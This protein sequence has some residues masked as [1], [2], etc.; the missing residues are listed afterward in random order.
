VRLHPDCRRNTFVAI[1]QRAL[2]LDGAMQRAADPSRANTV[3]E[4][5]WNSAP[6]FI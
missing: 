6:A 3:V 4:L 5:S 2:I 1:H